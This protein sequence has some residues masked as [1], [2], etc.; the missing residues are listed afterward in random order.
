MSRIYLVRHGQASLERG[1]A[2]RLTPAG[3]RQC[4]A[5][6]RHWQAIGRRM[7]L[8]FAGTL[9]RQFESAEAFA[10]ATAGEAAAAAAVRRLPGIEEYDHIALIAA[11]AGPAG[12]PR[13]ARELHGRLVPA[14]QAWVEGRLDGVE[15]FAE[16]RT[17]CAAALAA[18]IAATGR[19]RQA[20]LFASAGS[21]A[22]AMQS[23]LGIGDRDLLRLKLTFYNTGV[24]CLLSD[25][26]RVTI[27]SVN[28]IGHLERPDLMP[29]IT[30]R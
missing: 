9:P 14:L 23:F 6:A 16:F 17:R 4:E 28:A 21:L 20:V 13:D 7:D 18:A 8:V 5:L 27:E 25:G 22:A 24:S 1:G 12:I 10:R 19:G 26:E 3:L 15:P 11:H 30:H 29:L 2:G